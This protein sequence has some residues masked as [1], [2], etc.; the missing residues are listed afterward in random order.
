M[1]VVD[2]LWQSFAYWIIGTMT[3]DSQM[4]ARYAG[5]YKGVQSLGATVAWQLDA[6]SVPLIAQLITNWVL[7]NLAI[8]FM[9]YVA[10]NI[11]DTSEE[12]ETLSTNEWQTK[13]YANIDDILI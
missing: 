9:L 3:N 2:A 1:G 13:Y 11:K 12:I 10:T 5:F 8:P 6:Q 4:L 7:L